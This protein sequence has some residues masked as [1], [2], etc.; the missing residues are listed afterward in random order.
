MIPFPL[1]CH[2]VNDGTLHGLP[3]A[4]QQYNSVQQLRQFHKNILVS[5]LHLCIEVFVERKR[6]R[7]TE[8][9]PTRHTSDA[10]I[11]NE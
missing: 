4:N 8:H 1:A 6:Q 10:H 5:S 3:C 11:S 7:C 2:T 9:E